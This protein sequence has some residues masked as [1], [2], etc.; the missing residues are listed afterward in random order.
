MLRYSGDAIQKP[1]MTSTEKH[2]KKKN[3]NIRVRRNCM[4]IIRLKN[5]RNQTKTPN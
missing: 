4:K 5:W 2:D 3:K 1:Q